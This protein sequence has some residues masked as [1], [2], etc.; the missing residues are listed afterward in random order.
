DSTKIRKRSQSFFDH[1]S[2]PAL[3]YNS[4]TDYEKRHVQQAFSFELG[5]VNIVAIRQRMVNMLLEVDTELA[6]IVAN[7]LGL[8]PQ[9]LP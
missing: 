3:F 6:T 4:L 9:R 8:V 5:K 2:Q 1:F 7:N